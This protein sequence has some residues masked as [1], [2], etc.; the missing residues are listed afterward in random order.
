MYSK[1]LNS[2]FFVPITHVKIFSQ[3]GKIFSI[4]KDS[5]VFDY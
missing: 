4:E 2:G 1:K 3:Y 5:A